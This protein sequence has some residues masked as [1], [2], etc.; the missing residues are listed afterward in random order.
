M[1]HGSQHSD[2]CTGAPVKL[3]SSVNVPHGCR[4]IANAYARRKSIMGTLY[5]ED[6]EEPGA[7]NPAGNASMK[8]VA[9]MLV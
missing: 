8:W 6:E 7:Q 3:A 9:C 2:R 1:P 4:Y 5:G